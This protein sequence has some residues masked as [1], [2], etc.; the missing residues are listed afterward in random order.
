MSPETIVKDDGREFI[1]F[2]YPYG[3]NGLNKKFGFVNSGIPRFP[4]SSIE[5]VRKYIETH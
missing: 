4:F 3:Y 5:A 1:I 2:S